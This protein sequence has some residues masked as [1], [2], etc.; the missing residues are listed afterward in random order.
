MKRI[1]SVALALLLVL[2]L[3]PVANAAELSE[4]GKIKEQEYV[5][6]GE[7]GSASSTSNNDM[8]NG[9]MPLQT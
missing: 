2:G 5:S 3:L 7:R 9:K 8:K 4:F 1:L 6:G